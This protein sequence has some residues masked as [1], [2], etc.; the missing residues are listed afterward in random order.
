MTVSSAT[1]RVSFSGNASTTVFAYNFK[2]FSDSDLTVILRSAAGVETT[3]TL[4]THY[5]V[6]GAGVASGGNVTFGSAP[7]SGVTVVILREQPLTQGLDL[8]ANDPFPSASV[9]D[10]LDKLTFMIQQHD[11]E[12]GRAIKASKTNTISG[13]EFTVSSADRANKV[14]AFDSNGDLTVTQELGEFQGNWAASTAYVERDLVKDTSTNNIFIALTGHTS[15]GS[16]PLTTNTD[17]AKWSVIVTPGNAPGDL[18]VGDDLSLTS[19]SAILGFGADTDVTLTHVADTGLLL[20]STRQLQFNDASQFINAPSA[21]VLDI[22]ATDEIEL[23]A[24]LIDV[25]GNLDVSGTITLGSGAVISEAELEMI[26]G[27]TAGTVAA[28]KAVVVDANKDAAS[29]RNLT[30]T[31]AITGG[32]FVIG[33]AD[34]NENDLESID[35]IT[36]GTVA[37]SKAMVVDSNKD[38]TGARNVTITGELDA[39]TLD[40]SGDITLNG[41]FPTGTGNAAFG[42]SA[43]G[44]ALSTSVQNTAIGSNA[45]DSITAGDY[46]T[47]IGFQSLGSVVTTDANTAVGHNALSNSI[48]TGNTG[49]GISAG[50]YLT[51][52]SRNVI[53]GSYDGNEGGLDIR[54]SSNNVVLSD[55]DGNIRLYSN[56]SGNVGIKNVSPTTALDVTGTITATSLD[57]SGDIDVDGTTNLD[58]VDIDGAVDMASTLGVTGVLTTTAATVF[59]GGFTSNGDTNT[60]T[61]ANAEDPLVILKNTTN[62]ADC[63]RLRF[64]KDKGAAG[65][66]GDDSGEIEF[67]ADNDAQQQTLFARI[68]GEVK[69]ASD[70]AEG[71]HFKFQVASHDGEMITALLLADGNAEDEVDVVIGSGASSNTSVA[72]NLGITGDLD[73]DGTTNLDVVDIDGAV[74]MA[75][76]ALVTGVLTTTAA[77]VFNGGFQANDG[78]TITTAD[79]T[80]QLGIVSTDTDAAL[81]PRFTIWRNSSSPA[82][83]DIL[84]RIEWYGQSDTGATP[85]FA[86]IGVTA[87]DVSNG[88]ED[89]S[90]YISTRI[91]GSNK[92]R[93]YMPPTETVF[94]EESADVDFRV[95]SDSNTH[96]LFVDAGNNRVGINESSPV[97]ALSVNGD[98]LS[99]WGNSGEQKIGIAGRGSNIFSSTE[100]TL[101]ITGADALAGSQAMQGGDVIVRGGVGAGN[102]G[103]SIYAGHLYLEGGLHT[104][105]VGA[106]G[107]AGKIYMKTAGYERL[108]INQYGQVT[109]N[110]VGDDADFR[111]ESSSN[112]NML[113]V[114]ASLD[115]V[116]IGTTLTFGG[117]LNV[118]SGGIG[119]GESGSAG[120]YRRIYWN[121]AND[122]MR[123]WN[124]TNEARITDGGAFTNASDVS[125]KKD[126]VEIEYGIDTVKSLKP[127][128]YKLKSSDLEQIGF[129]AQEME[130]QVPEVVSTGITPDGDEQKGISYG[131]LTAVL[132]KAMQEQQTLIETLEARITALENA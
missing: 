108:N 132:T 52:G 72:G 79:N 77:T 109:I 75:T 83:N 122:E 29:F 20:N 106:E 48:G 119:V 66:D 127:R 128:K 18:T 53:L 49:L 120:Y 28:S 59:N 82:D 93:L 107:G 39:A 61:S 64:V 4:T 26:D 12:L 40:I 27:I 86:H 9:E 46:N 41:S 56:S 126:I 5:T 50:L 90:F 78:C 94:N 117:F 123:F 76:T 68:K 10:S 87:L 81:G 115:T 55:G 111:V 24:T 121:E 42:A 71:G 54:T 63:A 69:D 2:I 118:S 80:N 31:G 97:S 34:I 112:A 104:G 16:Q 35:G 92:N 99:N 30:A 114:D 125:L 113:F 100:K 6:S 84:G 21:T 25:N 36:A 103:L 3:Q 43:L 110:E 13:N 45:G 15:S 32:S 67:Y 1:N 11:E 98:I 33:S 73:V 17:A 62:D 57:I 91:A 105:G 85:E 89:S 22:N 124:G 70:G 88:T 47:A 102:E 51:S 14:F 116:Q 130:A 60:F 101:I 37:A 74:D 129:V 19:D 44:S 38:I 58:V 131:Q 7:A 23:N 95:E 8:V 65:V 96:M